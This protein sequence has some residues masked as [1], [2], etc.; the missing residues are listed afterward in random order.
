MASLEGLL[1]MV[2]ICFL[3]GGIAVLIKWL[4]DKNKK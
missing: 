3:Y 4:D 1:F 2:G